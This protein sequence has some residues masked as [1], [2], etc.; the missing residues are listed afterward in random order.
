MEKNIFYFGNKGLAHQQDVFTLEWTGKCE[1]L[2]EVNRKKEKKGVAE[3]RRVFIK[4]C[5]YLFSLTNKIN[6]IGRY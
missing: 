6:N 2:T 4:I 5:F 1:A 3:S